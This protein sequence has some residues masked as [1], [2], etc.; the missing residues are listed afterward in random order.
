MLAFAARLK[1]DLRSRYLVCDGVN[2]LLL[3]YAL[4]ERRRLFSICQSLPVCVLTDTI[5]GV[6]DCSTIVTCSLTLS[7]LAL[8][9]YLEGSIIGCT[10]NIKVIAID[11]GDVAVAIGAIV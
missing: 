2:P 8:V 10:M 11:K 4:K 6:E 9:S 5:G 7:T 1:S 3:T